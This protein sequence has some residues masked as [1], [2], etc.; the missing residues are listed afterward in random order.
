M[1][2]TC[3][4]AYPRA[5]GEVAISVQDAMLGLQ[6]LVAGAQAIHAVL[7]LAAGHIKNRLALREGEAKPRRLSSVV[8]EEACP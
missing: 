8:L 4:D 7:S 6:K 5:L 1:C 2:K 3:G